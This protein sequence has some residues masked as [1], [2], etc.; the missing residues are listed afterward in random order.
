MSVSH[1]YRKLTNHCRIL[2]KATN[3]VSEA[4]KSTVRI[5]KTYLTTKRYQVARHK[6]AEETTSASSVYHVYTNGDKH[7]RKVGCVFY[8]SETGQSRSQPLNQITIAF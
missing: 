8:Y 6:E 7:K 1:A 2:D 4:I 3:I 5:A